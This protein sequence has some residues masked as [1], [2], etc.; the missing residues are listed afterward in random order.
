MTNGKGAKVL[1]CSALSRGRGTMT[2]LL[3]ERGEKSGGRWRRLHGGHYL[4]HRKSR[5]SMI[6]LL[7]FRRRT[8][9]SPNVRSR[10]VVRRN[11][12]FFC[13]RDELDLRRAHFPNTAD[14]SHFDVP[15]CTTFLFFAFHILF[16]LQISAH[17]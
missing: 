8:L 11:T 4:A 13:R 9:F 14:V 2:L 12:Y 5:R 6:R 3:G 16:D 1:P 15:V 7:V 10:L 17:F